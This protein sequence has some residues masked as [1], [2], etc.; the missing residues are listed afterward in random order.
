MYKNAK[1][2]LKALNQKRNTFNFFK[3]I[4]LVSVYLSMPLKTF[5]G[6]WPPF[7]FLNLFT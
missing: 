1:A 6:P 7:Q 3:V 5:V 4:V 2:S